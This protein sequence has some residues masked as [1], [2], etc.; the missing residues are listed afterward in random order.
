MRRNTKG[1][2]PY[3]EMALKS[4]LLT[5][6]GQIVTVEDG[7][8]RMPILYYRILYDTGKNKLMSYFTEA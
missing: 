1:L 6:L 3:I 4:F 7:E 8:E 2:F 5:S